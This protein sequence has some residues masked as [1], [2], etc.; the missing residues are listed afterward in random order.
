MKMFRDLQSACGVFEKDALTFK[1]D[2]KRLGIANSSFTAASHCPDC[3]HTHVPFPLSTN[4]HCGD[5]SYNVRCHKG[6]LWFDTVKGSSYMITTINPQTQRFVIRPP[7]LASDHTCVSADFGTQGMWLDTNAPFNITSSNTLLL[8][9]CS[10][11]VLTLLWNCSSS[12]ICHSYVK[13]RAAKACR[14]AICCNF[15]TGGSVTEYRIRVRKE[16]CAAY[17]SFPNM[18]DSAPVS[19][20]PE[21][22]VEIGWELPQEPVCKAPPDC[23]SLANSTCSPV[24]AM[25][26]MRKCLCNPDFQWDP[27]N[28]ICQNIKCENGR[29]CNRRNKKKAQLVGGLA[30]SGAAMLTGILIAAV[31]YGYRRRRATQ[32]ISISKARD[33]LNADN[34]GGRSAKIFTIKEITK[35]TN[36]FSKHNLLGSGGF[37][38]VFMGTLAD[39]SLTAIKRAKLGNTRAVEQI[40]NEVRILCQLNHRSLVRLL[41]CCIELHNEPLLVYEYVPN[42]TLFDHLHNTTKWGPLRWHRRLKI[43]HQTAEGLSYLHNSA[44]P[45]IF[46]R[47][48]KSS[49][50]LLDDNLNAK[51]SDFGLSK[52]ATSEASHITTCAQGTLG[53]LDPEYYMNFQ[54]TD[55]SD[56]YSFGVVLLEILTAKKALDFG[57]DEEDVNLAVFV[58]REMK[59]TR[60]M[61]VIDPTLKMGASKSELESMKELGCLAIAC[62]DEQRQNRPSMKDVA[63]E[64]EF[65]LHTV[66]DG[67]GFKGEASDEFILQETS[68]LQKFPGIL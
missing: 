14:G 55:K 67:S 63:D 2:P 38:E 1:K 4:P 12:S 37:G 15:R 13:A 54:L 30:F 49:N 59:S 11:E 34:N 45:R 10:K 5:P 40:L 47:D 7:S 23:G 52:L 60:L 36:N 53:Y 33:I 26:G 51:V 17:V 66:S 58:K 68:G 28:G 16:R 3:G 65:I 48:I 61:E 22:G 19:K 64:I 18:D 42:G 57:R 43:A 50:I 21:P 9:N 24:A 27:V 8:M 44:I 29:G 56:V 31:I 25:G 32:L 35:A 39:G 41:G 46:H 62:L 20:W 6:A